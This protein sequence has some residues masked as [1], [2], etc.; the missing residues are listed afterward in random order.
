M[1][2]TMIVA[3]TLQSFIGKTRWPEFQTP[4]KATLAYFSDAT[5]RAIRD[6]VFADVSDAE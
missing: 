3:K 2:R 6:E 5:L 1:H 4:N